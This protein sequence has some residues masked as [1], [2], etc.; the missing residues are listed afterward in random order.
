VA[1]RI[2]PSTSRRC[3]RRSFVP[4]RTATP[5]LQTHPRGRDDLSVHTR[6]DCNGRC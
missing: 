6:G 4:H 3:E 2:A 1:R 5:H